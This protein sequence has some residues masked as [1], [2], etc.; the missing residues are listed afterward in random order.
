MINGAFNINS[1]NKDAWKA[2]LAGNRFLKHPADTASG[3]TDAMFP[4]SLEQTS[5]S[6]TPPSGAKDDSFSGYRRLTSQEIDAVAGEIVK[7]V[8]LRGPFVSLSHFV[9]R[10]LVGL[11][12]SST[13]A[14]AISRSGALQS[15]LDNSGVNITPDGKKSDF[16]NG[17][18]TTADTVIFQFDEASHPKADVYGGQFNNTRGTDYEGVTADG[19][20]VWAS[21]SQDL[22]V[23]SVASILADRPMLTNSQYRPEQGFRSTGIPGWVTQADVL[24]AIGPSI[25]ARSDTFRIR[26]YGEALSPDGKTVIAKACCEAVVQRMPDYI[27]ASNTPSERLTSLSDTTSL[28]PLN[29]RFGRK[30]EIVSFRW[31][32]QIEI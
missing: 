22:N 13:G 16:S 1:T 2:L 3:S 7:Q 10:G 4:R 20:P 11:T 32:S 8:R 14:V 21:Q 6:A 5:P 23:G 9:N 25:A 12:S 27:D 19:D 15:A 26:S 28:T 31:L 29:K 18:S 24:Q 30:F 17:F